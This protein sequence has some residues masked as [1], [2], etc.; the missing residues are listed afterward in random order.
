[1]RSR[2]SAYAT[3]NSNYLF[4]TTARSNQVNITKEQIHQWA[5]QTHWLKL[6]IDTAELSSLSNYTAEYWPSVQFTALYFHQHKLWQMTERSVFVV[7]EKQWKYYSGDIL[8]DKQL[9]NPKRNQPCPC[10]SNKKFKHCCI[11]MC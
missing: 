6:T 3:L 1:M 8:I 10:G 5:A 4:D 2:Y 9:P 11:K 7:E